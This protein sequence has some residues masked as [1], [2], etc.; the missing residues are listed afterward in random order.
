MISYKN[1]LQEFCQKNKYKIPSYISRSYGPPHNLQWDSICRVQIDTQVYVFDTKT[2][3]RSNSESTKKGSENNAAFL[4]CKSLRIIGRPKT[5]RSPNSHHQ[6]VIRSSNS[7][8]TDV[9]QTPTKHRRIHASTNNSPTI[10]ERTP[11]DTKHSINKIYVIDMENKPQHKMELTD[12]CAVYLGFINST[13]HTVV[14]Y[15]NWK[16]CQ[17]DN[18]VEEFSNGNQRLLCLAEGGV[19]DL[20]DHYMSMFVPAVIQYIQKCCD[21]SESVTIYIVSGDHA[22]WCTTSCFQQL[23]KWRKMTNVEIKNITHIV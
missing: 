23:L 22:S 12:K 2:N 11:I 21:K 16:I 20:A 1:I 7:Y 9:V 17:S 5:L 15:P 10:R 4:A 14:K 18:L 19:A 13:H 6:E 8:N 3:P